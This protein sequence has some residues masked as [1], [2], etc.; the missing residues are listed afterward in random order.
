VSY[1]QFL[2]IFLVAPIIVLAVLLRRHLTLRYAR[3]V[4]LMGLIAFVYA[5]PWDNLIVAQGVWSYDPNRVVGI[6]LG[7][8][9]LEEYLFFLL[10]PI[11]AGLI[12]LALLTRARR[13]AG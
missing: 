4:G 12:V 10:Q 11:L 1:G 7:W 3:V 8:V 6:I 13:A 2:L 5:T 9:P